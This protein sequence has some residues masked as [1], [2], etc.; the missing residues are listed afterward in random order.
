MNLSHK[1]R[2]DKKRYERAKARAL[3]KRSARFGQRG[4]AYPDCDLSLVDPRQEP[5]ECGHPENIRG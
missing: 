1:R 5:S 3:K 4:R 2:M